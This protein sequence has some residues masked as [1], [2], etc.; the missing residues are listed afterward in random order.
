M[1]RVLA[2]GVALYLAVPQAP[3]GNGRVELQAST[4][5]LR[6]V[7]SKDEP[8]PGAEVRIRA[9]GGP[10]ETIRADERGI[11]PLLGKPCAIDARMPGRLPEFLAL[12][13]ES[14]SSHELLEPLRLELAIPLDVTVREADGSPARGVGL[15]LQKVPADA[16]GSLAALAA[17]TGG[18]EFT[19]EDLERFS[20]AVVSLRRLEGGA[21]GFA[22]AGITDETGMISWLVPSG[23]KRAHLFAQCVLPLEVYRFTRDDQPGQVEGREP[24]EACPLIDWSDTGLG[25]AKP[26]RSL[27]TLDLSGARSLRL[28]LALAETAT[29]DAGFA[30]TRPNGF[31]PEWSFAELH[32]E[33]ADD[34][35]E[36]VLLAQSPLDEHGNFRFQ[37]ALLAP[38]RT[39]AVIAWREPR[40]PRVFRA[41]L[42][43][44]WCREHASSEPSGNSLEFEPSPPGMRSLDIR[45]RASDAAGHEV[46][47]EELL[48]PGRG[49][50]F[51]IRT[52][53]GASPFKPDNRILRTRSW[54]VAVP[55]S[56]AVHVEGVPAQPFQLFV[57]TIATGELA[58]ALEWIPPD[59]ASDLNGV[60]LRS[61][62]AGDTTL[63]AGI[64]IRVR[65]K[66]Q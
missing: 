39:V 22:R 52:R 21:L 56:D 65:R 11:V 16:A 53:S 62:G 27:V 18:A 48:D 26:P 59:N 66:Q 36:C 57:G 29:L 51:E 17:F 50:S 23:A 19:T 61:F 42:L 40:E 1:P 25:T 45:F 63:S 7:R 8:L 10:L 37:R 64:E 31:L 43:E 3:P 6:I 12:T 15:Q 9:V 34:R 44:G 5:E 4:L 47:I 58:D 46:P 49:F 28:E 2:L 30:L 35:S 20:R 13:A 54:T 33:S 24:R 32:A 38:A 55:P 41:R 60:Y 14:L